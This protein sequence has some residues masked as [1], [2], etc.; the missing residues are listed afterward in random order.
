[1][2]S[3]H[4][5]VGIM[6]TAVA[7]LQVFLPWGASWF[8]KPILFRW[9]R[10]YTGYV[11]QMLAMLACVTGGW[12]YFIRFSDQN[13]FGFAMVI[14]LFWQYVLFHNMFDRIINN[15]LGAEK[16][17]VMWVE[18]DTSSIGDGDVGNIRNGHG[19]NYSDSSNSQ[20]IGRIGFR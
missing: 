20:T 14:C 3:Y 6:A 4:S 17:R 10:L 12:M 16:Q 15:M 19:D 5:I 13:M 2:G 18:D 11:A 7:S 8:K 9:H 1:V